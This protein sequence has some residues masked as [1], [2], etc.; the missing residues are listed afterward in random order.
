MENTQ[1]TYIDTDVQNEEHTEHKI[2]H[3]DTDV[4]K[5]TQKTPEQSH[6]ETLKTQRHRCMEKKKT[7]K[8]RHT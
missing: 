7:Q 8:N 2:N 1:A 3:E 4:P 6:E 5:K